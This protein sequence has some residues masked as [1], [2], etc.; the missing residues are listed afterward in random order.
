MNHAID[1]EYFV[2]PKAFVFVDKTSGTLRFEVKADAHGRLPIDQ[3]L[4][5]LVAQCLLRRQEPDDFQ[6]MVAG[7]ENLLDEL[8]RPAAELI[9]ACPVMDAPVALTAR[10]RQVL[11]GVLQFLS[12]KEIA[13][14]LKIS[15]RT[16]KFH[17]SALL[18]KFQVGRRSGLILKATDLFSIAKAPVKAII[19][20]VV[21]GA[22]Q[23]LAQGSDPSRQGLFE[24]SALARRSQR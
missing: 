13:M 8:R 15:V 20:R 11:A 9:R 5:L 18:S 1:Q 24:I 3:A 16:V 19:P 22:G 12:N 21:V 4:S 14:K 6:V 10:E 2:Q 23:E 17:V 7:S